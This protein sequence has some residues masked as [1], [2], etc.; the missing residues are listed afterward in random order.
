MTAATAA[1]KRTT[2]DSGRCI[3]NLHSGLGT[4]PAAGREIDEAGGVAGGE[5]PRPTPRDLYHR[6]VCARKARGGGLCYPA[7]RKTLV[8]EGIILIDVKGH[9]NSRPGGAP[10]RRA[11]PLCAAVVV[12]HPGH[13]L[14]VHG[15]LCALRPRLLVLTDG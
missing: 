5:T 14:R 3:E 13:E 12:A 8:G 6:T 7:S 11:D 9:H 10:L 2:N 1:A 4:C 15:F